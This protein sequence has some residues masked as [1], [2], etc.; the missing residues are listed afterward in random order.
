MERLDSLHEGHQ[1]EI[2]DG[3]AWDR[4]WTAELDARFA[5]IEAGAVATVPAAQ[6]LAEMRAGA[7]PAR[8]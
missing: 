8:R 6:V 3:G 7:L 4:S 5:C 1:G 2:L